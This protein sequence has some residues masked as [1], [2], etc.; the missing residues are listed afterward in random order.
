M[1][2]V[3]DHRRREHVVDRDRIAVEGRKRI[4]VRIAALICRDL[5]ERARIVVIGLGVASSDH[6][7]ARILGNVA[8]R[9]LELG[10][11]RPPVAG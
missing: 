7:V 4:G 2:R 9:N 11:R 6:R 5:R 1:E 10:L 3:G 8:E